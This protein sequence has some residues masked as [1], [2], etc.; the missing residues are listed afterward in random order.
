MLL[1]GLVDQGDGARVVVDRL[2]KALVAAHDAAERIERADVARVLAREL[3]QQLLRLVD[4]LELI[5]VER[6]AD[7][8]ARL[9]RR[10]LGDA[11]VGGDGG[12][13]ALGRLVGVGE[14]GQR[15]RGIRRQIERELQV[16]RADADAAFAGQRLAQTVERLRQA[17]GGGGDQQLGALAGLDLAPAARARSDARRSWSA[18]SAP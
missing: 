2:G 7:V 11:I 13:V 14:R 15:E 17:L 9:Q 4:A 6:L 10:A 12:L 16:D 5:E 1:L 3:V 8:D 18:R